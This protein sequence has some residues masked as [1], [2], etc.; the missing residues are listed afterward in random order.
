MISQLI[1]RIVSA[2]KLLKLS[3]TKASQKRSF[4][5]L[6]KN[7]AQ[8]YQDIAKHPVD[9]RFISEFWNSIK[10][11]LEPKLLPAPPISFFHIPW[12]RNTMV[13]PI[14]QSWIHPE[15]SF[16]KEYYSQEKLCTLVEEDV[17]GSPTL[18]TKFSSSANTLHHTYHWTRF[19]DATKTKPENFTAIIE[20]GGGYGNAA[21]LFRRMSAHQHTYI[22]VDL[23]IFSC[24]QWLYLT[25]I[26]GPD[27]VVL[28]T[29]TRQAITQGKINL[30]PL[31]LIENMNTP[32]DLF[33]STWAL[34]ESNDY[35][36]DFVVDKNWFSAKHLLLAHQ[37]SNES[38]PFGSRLGELA[39]QSGAQII[40]IPFVKKSS[41]ALR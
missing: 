3:R 1:I 5:E 28:H 29:E 36:Q 6:R 17:I 22:I 4:L 21:K 20:W 2:W 15:L 35:A 33:V 39:Q 40:P 41:Y 26:L 7:F 8:Y 14:K 24:L 12:I 31:S 10:K 18:I 23:P 11:D 34:S 13:A 27:A 19:F 25:S 38:I 16:L 32:V 37:Q 30:V 9:Q